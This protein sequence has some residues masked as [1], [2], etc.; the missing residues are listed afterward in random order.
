MPEPTMKSC[1]AGAGLRWIAEGWR[2]FLKAP[3]T[4]MGLTLFWLVVLAIL[5]RI[6]LIGNIAAIFFHVVF[7][8]GI[9]LAAEA[10]DRALQPTFDHAFQI[11][12]H[13]RLHSLLALG[14]ANLLFS[15]VMAVL[16]GI[17]MAGMRGGWPQ[18]FPMV[19]P[20]AYLWGLALLTLAIGYLAAVWFA[21][22]L[23]LFDRLDLIP[24][25]KT[26]FQAVV[27]NVAPFFLYG[28]AMTFLSLIALLPF[29]I[30]L[31]ILI[32]VALLSTYRA[33]REIFHLG[34]GLP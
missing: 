4:W 10:D 18:A 22:L 12:R 28:L 9:F 13:P 15:I 1:E 6:P 34:P 23:I 5:N 14:V 24:A 17:G 19:H 32:P 21:P 26:S 31:L 16:F 25:L 2:L 27:R 29:G 11:F 7:L 3:W 20:A 33:W 8:G 30:G